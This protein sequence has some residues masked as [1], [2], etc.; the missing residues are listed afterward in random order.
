MR[1][2]KDEANNAFDVLPK[3]E[4]AAKLLELSK[5]DKAFK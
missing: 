1:L 2:L 4:K 5:L 3:K